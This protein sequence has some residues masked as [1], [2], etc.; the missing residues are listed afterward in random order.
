M[1]KKTL[2]LIVILVIGI[3]GILLYLNNNNNDSNPKNNPSN[4]TGESFDYKIIHSVNS[5]YNGNY[6][7]SPLSIAYALSIVNEGTDNNAKN[8]ISNLLGNYK[9]YPRVNVKERISIANSLFV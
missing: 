8:E 2:I 7:I 6:L 9:L 1:K 4:P 3:S 5:S